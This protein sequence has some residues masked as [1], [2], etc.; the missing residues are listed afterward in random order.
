MLILKL[1]LELPTR[2]TMQSFLAPCT[3]AAC[4]LNIKLYVYEHKKCNP[5]KN[6]H[7]FYQTCKVREQKSNFYSS[8]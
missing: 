6:V 7:S 4:V 2:N 8:C 3:H 1:L 5:D